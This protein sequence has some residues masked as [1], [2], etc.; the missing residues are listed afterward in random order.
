MDD[1]HLNEALSGSEEEAPPPKKRSFG[2]RIALQFPSKKCEM[3]DKNSS[4][5]KADRK[6]MAT[7]RKNPT[8]REKIE[9]DCEGENDKPNVENSN[10]LL[11]RAMN[12]KENKAVVCIGIIKENKTR[13][14]E[15]F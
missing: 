9:P 12:I 14:L 15:N 2:L 5:I 13:I 6:K 11:K 7:K 8:K 4:K 10:A 3:K 1:D